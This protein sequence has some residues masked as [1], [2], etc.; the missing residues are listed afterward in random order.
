[1]A[2]AMGRSDSNKMILYRIRTKRYLLPPGDNLH[3]INFPFFASDLAYLLYV[4]ITVDSKLH[5]QSICDTC[6]KTKRT[7]S[8]GTERHRII[9]TS[10]DLELRS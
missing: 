1:M 2:N 7:D 3:S 10:L 9:M 6:D 8:N 4:Q 5:R